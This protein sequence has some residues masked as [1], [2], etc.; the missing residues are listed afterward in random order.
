[1]N[2]G[3]ISDPFDGEKIVDIIPK[4][5][6]FV[7]PAP[8]PEMPT[9][10][11]KRFVFPSRPGSIEPLTRLS[12]L[13]YFPGRHL[14]SSSLQNEQRARVQRLMLRGRSVSH[15][16]VT[17]LEIDWSPSP[18]G[19]LLR[20]QPGHA[21]TVHGTDLVIDH[22]VQVSVRDL[23]RFEPESRTV[24]ENP[25]SE[26]PPAFTAVLLL[27]PGFAEDADFPESVQQ[28][29][30]TD[31]SPGP[32]APADEV[33]YKTTTTDAARFV[34]YPLAEDVPPFPTDPLWRNRAAA[35]IF[36]LE[37]QGRELPWYA[38]GTPIALIGFDDNLTPRWIDR[39]A[40]VRPAGRPRKRSLAT[41]TLPTVTAATT[42]LDTRLIDARHWQARFDQFCAQL[43]TLTAPVPAAN[44]FEVLPPI[45]VLPKAYLSLVRHRDAEG[46][47]SH[48]TGTQSFFPNNYLFDIN[49]VPLE[50]LDSLIADTVTLEPY[51]L[52]QPDAVSVLIPVSQRWFDPDLLEVEK[53]DPRFDA[54][55]NL[56]RNR[57]GALLATAFDLASRRQLLEIFVGD[58]PT[59]APLHF[60]E[61]DPKRLETPE[62]PVIESLVAEEQYAIIRKNAFVTSDTRFTTPQ[63][64]ALQNQFQRY[65]LNDRQ[66]SNLKALLPSAT[67]WIDAITATGTDTKLSEKEKDR[68]RKALLESLHTQ[69][70]LAY[71]SPLIEKLRAAAT[72]FVKEFVDEDKKEFADL[73]SACGFTP[74]HLEE[75]SKS[76]PKDA[77]IPPWLNDIAELKSEPTDKTLESHECDELRRE[78]LAY[79]FKQVE[80]QNEEQVKVDT[81][82]LDELIRYFDQKADDADELVEAG[83]L[84]A[85]TDVYRLGHLLNNNSLGTKFAASPTL[86]NIVERKPAKAEG[87]AVNAFASQLLANFAPAA[88]ARNSAAE[89]TGQSPSSASSSSGNGATMT[90]VMSNTGT[91]GS[92]AFNTQFSTAE[93]FEA[94]P[95]HQAKL[96]A[97]REKLNAVKNSFKEDDDTAKAARAAI[98]EAE[99]TISILTSQ[100][101]QNTLKETTANAKFTDNF[102]GNFNLLSQK[103][104][105]AIPLERLQPPLAPTIRQEIQD[106]RLEIF[107]RLTRLNLSLGDLTTDFVDTPGTV[108]RAV[109]IKAVSRLR[110][111][112]LITR[113][114]DLFGRKTAT[115]TSRITEVVDADES[116]HFSSGVSYADMAMAALR[117]VEKR[118]KE[119]RAFVA[120]C[121]KV[122]AQARALAKEIGAELARYHIELDEARQDVSVALALKA[123]EEARLK[124]INDHRAKV[125]AEHHEFL[126]FARPRAINLNV[127]QPSRR[128]EP[129]LLTE[130]LNDC[131]KTPHTPPP[132]LAALR[133]I[134]RS[135]PARWFVHAPAWL[136]KVDQWEHLRL[137]LDRSSRFNAPASDHDIASST[138]RHTQTL[139]KILKSRQTSSYLHHAAVKNIFPNALLVLSWHDLRHQALQHLTLGHLITHGPAHLAKAA[140]GELDDLFSVAAC[141]YEKFC[142]VPGLV[143]MVWS[144]RFSQLDEVAIDFRDFSR[145]PSWPK[146]AFTLRREILIH[147]DWLFG[148]VD[149]KQSEAV[150]LINDLIRIA[151]LL[152]SHA[153]VD[154][155]IVGQPVESEV[156]P[157]LGGLIK[158]KVDPARIRRGMDVY[159]KISETH[160]LR[161]VVDDISAAHVAAR[162]TELPQVNGTAIK[163][164]SNSNLLFKNAAR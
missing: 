132:D 139:N 68:L 164:T 107:E 84:K 91:S 159:Y 82:S 59:P 67:Q 60:L 135:S 36:D 37:R 78:L 53:I 134:F 32:R 25:P 64:D 106:G 160:T 56:Y 76:L 75:Y 130:P 81:A 86:A 114:F 45:G 87:V 88:V 145:M 121:Q 9:R 54:Y 49:V 142:D 17:G 161:A 147:V 140:S 113:R 7:S 137:L 99:T 127:D 122:L 43:G 4:L 20:V 72:E 103:Q 153:P 101:F 131:L 129:A 73:F 38:L 126:V 109:A 22:P 46:M 6:P 119:Y 163:L 85:R 157:A 31:F 58:T 24:E 16:V 136:A 33:Y 102:V 13:R 125:L 146:I 111:Q 26:P 89:T 47:P 61:D 144:E 100:S 50:Q 66:K 94:L 10:E 98:E 123:E 42:T 104:L 57:R 55:I 18:A 141:L 71:S 29:A 23:R 41:L 35:G 143:R 11:G 1:M 79:I 65:G 138:G 44:L 15:G 19:A 115:E 151:I 63:F 69:G 124:A 48:W 52:G 148:R 162:V 8:A 39:H 96:T 40:V 80:I 83:F 95:L 77:E 156:T 112:T 128:I 149:K 108:T 155:L 62:I 51:K 158:I 97:Q 34:L 93:L 5:A 118:I 70:G 74:D 110:F 133:D 154:Q 90:R 92:Q 105:R 120:H 116:K 117:A 150:D 27:Q 28:D 3:N 12:R 2:R 30:E 152:S 21:L 14:T